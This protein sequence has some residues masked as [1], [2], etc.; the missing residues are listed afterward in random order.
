MIM[1]GD[2]TRDPGGTGA[3]GILY[4]GLFVT[5][6]GAVCLSDVCHP[7]HAVAVLCV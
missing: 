1:E 7:T 6:R 5:T 2:V 3:A 4:F